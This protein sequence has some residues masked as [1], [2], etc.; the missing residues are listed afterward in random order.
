METVEIIKERAFLVLSL[1]YKQQRLS[2]KATKLPTAW[3][4]SLGCVVEPWFQALSH[5]ASWLGLH[6][7]PSPLPLPLPLSLGG[8]PHFNLGRDG[9]SATLPRLSVK[10]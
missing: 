1:P 10:Q 3:L 5:P 7:S 9:I 4:P 2:S 6:L 8:I